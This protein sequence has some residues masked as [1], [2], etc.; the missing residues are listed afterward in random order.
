MAK[1]LFDK[2]FPPLSVIAGALSFVFIPRDLMDIGSALGNW[3]RLLPFGP[4]AL[5]RIL[6]L[7]LM[8]YGAWQLFKLHVLP[9]FAHRLAPWK[10]DRISV[11]KFARIAHAEYGWRL[12]HSLEIL[13]LIDGVGQALADGTVKAYGRFNPER[14]SNLRVIYLVPI[15]RTYWR[16]RYL[17]AFDAL[18]LE[19][20]LQVVSRRYGAMDRLEYIDIHVNRVQARAWLAR[21][22]N[23]W[24]GRTERQQ[25]ERKQG[26]NIAVAAE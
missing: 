6:F 3:V 19:D 10:N 23:R 18:N 21:E 12:P 13:D 4:E 5:P 22:G 7:S 1:Q 17:E 16:R 9:S 15:P 2:L 20:N 14:Y 25:E 26:E 8:A 24:K 11:V